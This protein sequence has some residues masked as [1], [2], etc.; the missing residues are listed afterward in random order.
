MK[1][2]EFSKIK[3]YIIIFV[4]LIISVTGLYISSWNMFITGRSHSF[5]PVIF[6]ISSLILV[7]FLF[8]ESFRIFTLKN[9]GKTIHS[10]IMSE[11]EKES[12][13]ENKETQFISPY[14]IAQRIKK[15]TGR[16]KNQS[17]A[18]VILRNIAAEFNIMQGVLFLLDPEKLLYESS[19]EYAISLDNKPRSFS[20]GEGL[21]GQV[22]I[23]KQ[24]VELSQLSK[25]YR[26]LSSGLG[27]TYARF[28]YMIPVI[29][30][31]ECI[32]LIEFSTLTNI[33]NNGLSAL[34]ILTKELG[35]DLINMIKVEH[36]A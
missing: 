31:D 16:V 33:G 8:F 12:I 27:N 35:E 30:E 23:D 3:Y 21:H 26:L 11:V 28:L 6:L 22:V 19:S 1:F 29:Y 20:P 18:S 34:N 14:D 24:V 10:E 4:L 2:Q 7:I 17:I 36:E 13:S 15:K 32:A 9:S 25:T 5:I